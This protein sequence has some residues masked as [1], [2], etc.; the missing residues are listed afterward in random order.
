M[1]KPEERGD[2]LWGGEYAT[3]SFRPS[4]NAI[5]ILCALLALSSR[6]WAYYLPIELSKSWHR[7]MLAPFASVGLGLLG[8]FL[9]L[10]GRRFGDRG[11]AGLF[12]NA[13][14]CGVCLLLAAGLVLWW[15]YRRW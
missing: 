11:R 12:L 3:V 7:P 10:V 6:Y 9:A 1:A 5:S 14:I 13:T 15:T 2:D 4:W 8:L